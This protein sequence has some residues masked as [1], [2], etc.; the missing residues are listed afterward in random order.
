M[1][2]IRRDTLP[3][4][5][6]TMT[7]LG[8]YEVVRKTKTFPTG[9]WAVYQIGNM[10]LIEVANDLARSVSLDD[11]MKAIERGDVVRVEG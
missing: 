6:T 3:S 5:D 9:F 1:G 7:L 11:L 10:I 2:P 8:A 4:M